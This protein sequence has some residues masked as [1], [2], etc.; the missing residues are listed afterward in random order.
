[1]DF[2]LAHKNHYWWRNYHK[3]KCELP[4]YC[5]KGDDGKNVNQRVFQNLIKNPGYK[6]ANLVQV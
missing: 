5:R 2:E 6:M 1:M 3:G 4:V